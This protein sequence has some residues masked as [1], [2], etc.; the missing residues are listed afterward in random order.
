MEAATNPN[1]TNLFPNSL[2]LHIYKSIL[3]F[4]RTL[5]FSKTAQFSPKRD[6]WIFGRVSNCVVKLVRAL[7]PI[8]R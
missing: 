3:L 8:E 5:K 7:S 1:K 4:I 6:W 2:T